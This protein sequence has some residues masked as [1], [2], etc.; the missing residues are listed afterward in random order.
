MDL[1]KRRMLKRIKNGQLPG[2][3]D[4][5]EN[6]NPD[7]TLTGYE[8]FKSRWQNGGGQKAVTGAMDALNAAFQFNSM[9][10]PTNYANDYVGKYGMQQG[11]VQGINYNQYR[12]INMDAEENMLAKE[13]DSKIMQG[14][15]L[16]STAG[17]SLGLGTAAL[18]GATAGSWL[19]PIGAI[20]GLGIGALLGGI[21]GNDSKH[22]QER[23]LR[24]AQ[25]K[26]NNANEFWRTGALSAALRNRE[27]E[28]IGDTS[29]FNLFSSALG[30][31]NVNVKNGKTTNKVLAHT[32]AGIKNVK[33]NSR[34]NDGEIV[35]NRYKGTEHYVEGNPNKI[36]GEYGKLEKGDDVLSSTLVIPGTN[37]TIAEAY[38]IAK[39]QG[40][41]NE[42][43]D[44]IQPMARDM[45]KKDKSNNKLVHAWGGLENILAT[46]PGMIQSWRD[47]NSI[48]NDDIHR[49]QLNPFHKYEG[50]ISNLMRGRNISVYPQMQAITN[51]EGAQRYRIN[52][53]G[54]LS[55]MQKTISNLTNNMNSKIARANAIANVQQLRNQYD[56]ETADMLNNMGSTVMDATTRAQMFNEQM[57]ASAH[58]AK[59]QGLNMAKRNM[60]DYA[61]QFAKNAW[62][63]SQFDDMM[64]LYRQQVNAAKM[65]A[66]HK[67][68]LNPDGT[69]KMDTKLPTVKSWMISGN[70]LNAPTT[71]ENF[72]QKAAQYKAQQDMFQDMF[73]DEK[74]NS[75]KIPQK[76]TQE[77]FKDQVEKIAPGWQPKDTSL[78][79][80]FMPSQQV[81]ASRYGKKKYNKR[82]KK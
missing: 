21:F 51:A 11:Q 35:R 49:T 42:L 31:E 54:G 32:A 57:N 55:A 59:T 18:T 45:V 10:A 75:I 69:K 30:S 19:G 4:A 56:K 6:Y 70:L 29:K 71:P 52:Q 8:A 62:E 27:L 20:A 9:K 37:V 74:I 16:G 47:Y 41:E 66:Y 79:N 23:Q 43:V 15:T 7:K 13:R 53:S 17:L 28:N 26:Q 64:D 58:A 5:V 33:A 80:M 77:L 25:I 12:D 76:S 34:L 60:L 65:E 61:T 82:R 78:L 24:V 81:N 39:M 72:E 2:F 67:A 40:W 50:D 68:G 46:V 44:V 1:N 38:P 3:N 22:E 48:S 63:K 36:D 14:A 73:S